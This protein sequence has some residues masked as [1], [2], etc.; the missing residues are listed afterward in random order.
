LGIGYLVIGNWLLRIGNWE[1]GIGNW[2]L[3]NFG[4]L[5]SLRSCDFWSLPSLVSGLPSP[6]VSGVEP[7]VSCLSARNEFFPKDWLQL[8]HFIPKRELA[9]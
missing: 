9:D 2:L 3:I 5:Q 6:V 1:L 8:R 7:S 4:G